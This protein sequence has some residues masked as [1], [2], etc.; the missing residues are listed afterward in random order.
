MKFIQRSTIKFNLK[1][2]NKNSIE[3]RTH[4]EKP[5]GRKDAL[6]ELDVIIFSH[7]SYSITKD[8]DTSDHDQAFVT[9]YKELRDGEGVSASVVGRVSNSSIQLGLS[10][11]PCGS[12]F[13]KLLIP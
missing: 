13:G 5:W 1:M 9:Y 8:C 10:D 6:W 7:L 12:S 2:I 3:V 4:Q 11:R